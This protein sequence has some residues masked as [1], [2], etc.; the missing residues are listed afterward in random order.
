MS[1]I[2]FLEQ[3]QKRMREREKE[4]RMGR[5]VEGKKEGRRNDR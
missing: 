5:T 4:R 1:C 3:Q 2:Q